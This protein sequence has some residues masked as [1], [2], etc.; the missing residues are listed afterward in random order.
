MR[1]APHLRHV[2][3]CVVVGV[4]AGC[5]DGT[6]PKSRTVPNLVRLESSPGDYIGGG[7]THSYSQANAVITVLAAGARLS[8]KVTGD[9]W[10]VGDL[11]APSGLGRLKPGTYGGL[12]RY[13]RSDTAMGGI[14]WFGE[15][16]GCL[17]VTGSFTVDSITYVADSVSAVDLRFEQHCEG[18]TAALRGTIRWRADDPTRPAGPAAIPRGL[19]QPPPGSTPATG[20]FVYLASDAGDFIG[21]GQTFLITAP[22]APINLAATDGRV[23]VSAGGWFGVFQ[24]MN[25]LTQMKAGYYAGLLRYPIHNPTRG[26]LAWTGNGRGCNRISGWFAADRVTY[27][28]G[29]LTA[30]ELRFEQ[31]CERGTAALRGK[32]RWNN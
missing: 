20:N 22:N 4:N 27:A 7:E 25:T 30:L 21:G 9:E 1:F 17:V 28:N 31:H 12:P 6:G 14:S 29:V 16:R 10:W 11:Q 2:L 24:T 5:S 23:S 18:S 3:V 32:I 8:F 15:G 26:G 13:S 19:W